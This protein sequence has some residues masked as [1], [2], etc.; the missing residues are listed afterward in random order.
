[1]CLGHRKLAGR[2][3]F[4]NYHNEYCVP[5]IIG[6][7]GTITID[8]SVTVP[9][10][11]YAGPGSRVTGEVANWPDVALEAD[12]PTVAESGGQPGE[13]TF[14]CP[15]DD[16][17]GEITVYFVVSGTF[18]GADYS[19]SGAEFAGYGP[20]GLEFSVEFS[21]GNQSATV[22]IVPNDT[23][24][25]SGSEAVTLTMDGVSGYNLDSDQNTATVTIFNNDLPTVN[26]SA[27]NGA[28]AFTVSLNTP[29]AEPL[30]VPYTTTG[31]TATNGVDYQLISG[32]VVIPAGQTSATVSIQPIVD[33]AG[34][35][36]TVTLTLGSGTDYTL[37]DD[38]WATLD[39][40]NNA[41]DP[42]NP[43]G[44]EFLIGS[45][46]TFAVPAGAAALYLGFHDSWQW[47]DN[48]GDASV[49]WT[50]STGDGGSGMCPRPRAI[51]S[52]CA[53]GR[54]GGFRDGVDRLYQRLPANLCESAHRRDEHHDHGVGLVD[55]SAGHGA[56][57]PDGRSERGP[58]DR[59][60]LFHFRVGLGEH[61]GVYMQPGQPGGHVDPG[62]PA[63][64]GDAERREG[65]RGRQRDLH[66]DAGP[67]PG[68][69][70]GL[71]VHGELRD[72]GQTARPGLAEPTT[73][74]KPGR[75]ISRPIRPRR[76]TVT[77]QR[78]STPTRRRATSTSA[79]C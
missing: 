58:G 12:E 10:S 46:G 5:G 52:R 78:T 13:F 25:A 61:R 39:I 26:I 57:R 15:N 64:D 34:G 71:V 74:R 63:G 20:G 9:V 55:V 51:T 19:I 29:V 66:G 65:G 53:S 11:V 54:G 62:Q 70:L 69:L 47:F 31:G 7:G 77:V 59:G 43:T 2:R 40:E 8:P 60:G 76:H 44:T 50:F 28:D 32:D 48:T 23:G 67:P 45:G 68:A 14:Y 21:P 75:S 24:A 73:R 49:S 27:G 30:L 6:S 56:V 3:N 38:S 42:G 36:H 17:T 35:E 37:G 4:A 41:V 33:Q 22:E 16:A 79:W 72:A 18:P 1:M